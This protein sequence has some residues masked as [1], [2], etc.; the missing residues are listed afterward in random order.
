MRNCKRNNNNNNDR[1]IIMLLL[2]RRKLERDA[3]LKQEKQCQDVL[4]I[5]THT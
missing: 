5:H 1:R 4:N 3:Q 2:P